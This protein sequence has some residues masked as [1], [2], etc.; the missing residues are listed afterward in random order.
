MTKSL[1]ANWQAP[2]NVFACSTTRLSNG[3]TKNFDK[4]NAHHLNKLV[5][6]LKLPNNPQWLKQYHSNHCVVIEDTTNRT[7]DAS[8]T[9]TSNQVLAILTADCLPIVLTNLDGT[10]IGAIHAG[11]R[12]L[13][14]G[15][16]ENTLR[17]MKSKPEQLIA[18]IGPSICGQCYEVGKDVFQT[19]HENYSFATH[20]FQQLDEEKWLVNLQGLAEQILQNLLVSQIYQ[21][22]ACTFEQNDL[23]YS[24]RRESQLKGQTGRIATVVWFT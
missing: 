19:Y 22:K 1:L 20:F 23:Y 24:Y 2:N 9:K 15:I 16:I 6:E 7:A 10:E 5:Q 4:N 21:S 18:W 3:N 12:G 8:V 14:Q 13:S 11:W 17:Q